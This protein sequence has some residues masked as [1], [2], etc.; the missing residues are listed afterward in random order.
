MCLVTQSSHAS[1]LTGFKKVLKSDISGLEICIELV[2]S[3]DNQFNLSLSKFQQTL[4]FANYIQLMWDSFP[5]IHILD[6][7]NA[8]I[9]DIKRIILRSRLHLWHAQ[10]SASRKDKNEIA[11]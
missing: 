8:D 2:Y 11:Q 4:F 1:A 6:T 10:I 5:Q 9:T 3:I 7:Y